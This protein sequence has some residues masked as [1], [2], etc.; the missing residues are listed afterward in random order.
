MD[1]THAQRSLIVRR[2]G[3]GGNIHE[4]C[5]HFNKGCVKSDRHRPVRWAVIGLTLYAGQ[6][7]FPWLC[8][9]RSSSAPRRPNSHMAGRLITSCAHNPVLSC[10]LSG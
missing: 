6:L 10:A 7:F 3:H 5:H 9:S 8:T 1:I 4:T 2:G